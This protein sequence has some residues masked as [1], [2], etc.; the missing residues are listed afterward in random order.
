MAS[1]TAWQTKGHNAVQNNIIQS[2]ATSAVS[3]AFM[4]VVAAAFGYLAMTESVD[5]KVTITPWEMFTWLFCSGVIGVF[6]SALFRK[7]FVDDPQMIFADGVA[8]AETIN[9]LDQ[10]A[11]SKSKVRILGVAALA[12]VIIAFVRDGL[13]KIAVLG[14][15]MRYRVGIEWSVLNIGT[16]ML[17]GINV[18][19]S[20]L[21]FVLF[22]S[23]ST[24]LFGGVL[25][26]KF[27]H[28]FFKPAAAFQKRVA[29]AE[30]SRDGL[31]APAD[32]PCSR[33]RAA[34]DRG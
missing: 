10:G 25:W 8:A 2:A 21:F 28:M 29:K 24:V 30:G 6:F 17:I 11:S 13:G 14:L 26:S 22:I 5:V 32:K 4:C 31:P 18:G 15:A 7:Y 16:G 33:P 19:L 9:V 34:G 3:T 1:A 20:M 12:G 27:A 23:A